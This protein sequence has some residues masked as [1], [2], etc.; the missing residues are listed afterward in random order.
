MMKALSFNILAILLL[1]SSH[2][3]AQVVS[4]SQTTNQTTRTKTGSITGTVVIEN[5]QPLRNALIYVRTFSSA[6]PAQSAMTDSEGKFEL[7][8][9]EPSTYQIFARHSVYTLLPRDEGTANNYHIG[10]S[11]KLVMVKGG[12]ITGTVTMQTGEPVIGVRVRAAAVSTNE[13]V[14][15]RFTDDRGVYRLY[16]LPSGKYV[17]WAGGGGGAYSGGAYD[18]DVPTY[19]PASPRDTAAE[20]DVRAGDETTNVDI[21][22]RG[23]PGRIVSG[24]VNSSI[25]GISG[26]LVTLTPA[27]GGSQVVGVPPGERQGF[28][29][30]GVD[31]GE[32]TLTARSLQ[33]SGELAI[34]PPKRISVRGADVTGVELS[35]KPLGSVSGQ[36]VLEELKTKECGMREPLMLTETLVSAWHKQDE[37][38][39]AQPKFVWGLGAP[40]NADAQGNLILQN[41]APGNYYFVTRFVAQSWY[42]QSISIPSASAQEPKKTVDATRVWTTVKIGDRISGLKITLAEGAASLSGQIELA[43]GEAL[44]EKLFIYLVPAEKESADEVLRFYAAPVDSEGKIT[45]KNLAPGRYWLLGRPAIEGGLT[46]LRLPDETDSRA[47][48]RREAEA[49]KTEIELKPCQNVTDYRLKLSGQ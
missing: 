28:V 26:V 31:D 17:V 16:G 3:F 25:S 22:Y 33:Q 23:E 41:L 30:Y 48:L 47:K 6:R 1:T 39:K 15:E 13:N 2:A 7:N 8:G 27:D 36:V 19:A 38:A 14:Q 32:Y 45:L 11:V 5:G 40:A 34:S 9:L 12:V 21:R 46:K 35:L 10:D 18:N 20:I 4:T 29:L 24:T 42:L 49:G 43:E 44:A 37:A